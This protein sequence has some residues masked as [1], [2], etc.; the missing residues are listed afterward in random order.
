[1]LVSFSDSSTTAPPQSQSPSRRCLS[2]HHRR[3]RKH[4]LDHREP[5]EVKELHVGDRE[6]AGGRGKR[7]RRLV[8][9][10]LFVS[11]E[12]HQ[13]VLARKTG[14]G[15][16][17]QGHQRQHALAA[18]TRTTSESATTMKKLQHLVLA[19]RQGP[20]NST[21]SEEPS[22]GAPT[23]SSGAP[24]STASSMSSESSTAAVTTIS[25]SG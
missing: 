14:I 2:R 7:S 4:G 22:S 17:A 25:S 24:A 6:D 3:S 19:A 16:V 11:L 12:A 21:T 20:G 8:S 10:V 9:L 18:S 15:T 1:M 5:K 23:S 13:N